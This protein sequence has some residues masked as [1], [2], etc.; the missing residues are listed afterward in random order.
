MPMK[1]CE[2]AK[3]IEIDIFTVIVSLFI[4]FGFFESSKVFH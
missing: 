4:K 1:Y 2:F 3:E